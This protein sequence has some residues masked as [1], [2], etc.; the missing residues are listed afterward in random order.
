MSGRKRFAFAAAA[1]LAG[2][3]AQAQNLVTNGNFETSGSFGTIPGFSVSGCETSAPFGGVFLS[4]ILGRAGGTNAAAFTSRNCPSSISQSLA[5]VVGQQYSV[6]FFARVNTTVA[7]NDLR[8]TFGGTEL[9]NQMLTS[10]TFQQFTVL[11]T[12]TST[13]TLLTIFGRN[14]SN[15]NVIDD[16]AVTAVG[17]V[18]TVPEPGTWALLGTGLLA[19]GGVARRK[20]VG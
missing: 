6:S 13:S 14:A 10:N 4:G 12:A 5:T 15:S 9:F 2:G 16:I 18:S 11:A 8:V 1:M 7:S 17:P 20:R 19:V 3:S